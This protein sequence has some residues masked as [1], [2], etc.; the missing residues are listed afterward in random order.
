MCIHLSQAIF[1]PAVYHIWLQ[2][3]NLFTLLTKYSISHQENNYFEQH[4]GQSVLK[5]QTNKDSII[6]SILPCSVSLQ[7][8]CSRNKEDMAWEGEKTKHQEILPLMSVHYADVVQYSHNSVV[9]F[10]IRDNDFKEILKLKLS[11]KSDL[12]AK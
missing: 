9:K 11:V 7:T 2:T 8:I 1:F 5:N 6:F 12:T 10:Y 3:M 4:Y